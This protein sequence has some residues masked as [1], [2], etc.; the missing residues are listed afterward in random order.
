MVNIGN[1]A[2]GRNQ[3]QNTK[4]Q[5]RIHLRTTNNNRRIK[6]RPT[7]PN[8]HKY[9]IQKHYTRGMQTIYDSN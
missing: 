8:Q 2:Q 3:T 4:Q 9:K 7:N 6:R 5:I 1:R